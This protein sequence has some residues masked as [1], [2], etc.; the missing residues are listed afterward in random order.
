MQELRVIDI[1]ALPA[2]L[3]SMPKEAMDLDG[4]MITSLFLLTS[5]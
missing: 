5:H 3:G 1:Q 2:T 4:A